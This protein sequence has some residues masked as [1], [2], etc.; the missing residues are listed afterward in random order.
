MFFSNINKYKNVITLC[1]II[2]I[3]RLDINNNNN[4]KNT[5]TKIME[6]STL[7]ETNSNNSETSS[8]IK[9]C[10]LFD[11]KQS[12]PLI[13]NIKEIIEGFQENNETNPT[14]TK[15]E[16]NLNEIKIQL[17]DIEAIKKCTT[18][19]F[20]FNSREEQVYKKFI[21]KSFS[22]FIFVIFD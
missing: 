20:T 6:T 9:K 11:F 1:T 13:S 14:T 2:I 5:N 17:D 22:L 4:N 8:L 15:S 3:I 19:Q 7:N 18:C 21:T 16:L 12:K 10:S